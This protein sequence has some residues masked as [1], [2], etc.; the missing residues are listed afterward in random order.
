MTCPKCGNLQPVAAECSVCRVI[1]AKYR[2]RPVMP[3]P[4]KGLL[5]P[6][7]ITGFIILGLVA[8]VGGGSYA[9]WKTFYA[10]R[11][12]VPIESNLYHNSRYGLTL[13]LPEGW[14]RYSVKEAISC[15]TLRDEYSDQYLLLASPTTPAETLLVLNLSGL[16][17][18]Y[19]RSTGWEG[20]IADYNSR[21]PILFSEVLMVDGFQVHRMGYHVA[22][23]Y[24]EDAIFEAKGAL[25]EIYFYLPE[26]IA[27]ATRAGE[28]RKFINDNLQKLSPG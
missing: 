25:L 22:G 3:E 28:I 20:V 2:S 5:F 11:S 21:N 17:L 18:D 4:R 19:F 8:L 12:T 16:S 15:A 1:I 10:N 23:F 6:L 26:G 7:L 24:R 9:I 27:T 14:R 13:A